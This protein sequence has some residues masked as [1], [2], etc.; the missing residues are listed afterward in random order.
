MSEEIP[1]DAKFLVTLM[2]AQ[3]S[4]TADAINQC[5]VSSEIRSREREAELAIIKER[6]RDLAEEGSIPHPMRYHNAT[7]V[8]R[9]EREQW[10]VEHYDGDWR[11]PVS[12]RTRTWES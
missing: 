11:D 4:A 8:T 5:W 9:E 12:A 10:L 1:E 6:V 7:F 3:A 2:G